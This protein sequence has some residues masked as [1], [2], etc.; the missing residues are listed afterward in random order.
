MLLSDDIKSLKG[1]ADKTAE[2]FYSA[3]LFNLNDL[4]HYFPRNY[5]GLKEI[6]PIAAIT[7]DGYVTLKGKVSSA[8]SSVY[9]NGKNMTQFSFSDQSGTARVSVFNMPWLK[10]SLFAGRKLI[11]RV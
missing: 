10:K 7:G 3:G 9:R 6:S 4:L 1:I 2:A 8:V 11:M 5:E